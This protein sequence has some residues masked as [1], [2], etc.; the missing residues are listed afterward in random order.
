M[1]FILFLCCFLRVTDVVFHNIQIYFVI[2][3]KLFCVVGTILSSLDVSSVN[4]CGRRNIL[5]AC[6]YI[7]FANRI[8]KTM[9]GGNKVHIP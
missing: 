4:V 5:D 8:D 6:S 7:F 2:H 9:S 3:R 1:I